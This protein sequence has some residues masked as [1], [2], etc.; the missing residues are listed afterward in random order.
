MRACD[1]LTARSYYCHC[2]T[3]TGQHGNTATGSSRDLQ[4]TGA[5]NS[6]EHENTRERIRGSWSSRGR[7]R[8]SR[9]YL[10]T[11]GGARGNAYAVR[12][13]RVTHTRNPNAHSTRTLAQCSRYTARAEGITWTR[14]AQ[15]AERTRQRYESAVLNARAQAEISTRMRRDATR[16]AATLLPT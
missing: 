1:E 4:S 13:R 16:R 11:D 8:R 3:P 5:E 7:A 12:E 10:V 9:L 6:R 2:D 15:Q 14:T